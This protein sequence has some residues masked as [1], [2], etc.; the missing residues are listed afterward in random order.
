ML[1]ITFIHRTISF[2]LYLTS[3]AEPEI[4]SKV[5]GTFNFHLFICLACDLAEH[6]FSS[7]LYYSNVQS[8]QLLI[9][10]LLI[11]PTHQKS[12]Q[13]DRVGQ[14]PKPPRS[15]EAMQC[16]EEYIYIYQAIMAFSTSTKLKLTL[17]VERTTRYQST[18]NLRNITLSMQE[19]LAPF[20][21][22]KALN[23]RKKNVRQK[24]KQGDKSQQQW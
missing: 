19:I 24:T 15:S 21:I 23:Q 11:L 10:L 1:K 18:I 20:V 12:F 9:F 4:I 8:L 2:K 3:L 7:D 13:L 14:N 5:P 17:T 22:V 6:I 16:G